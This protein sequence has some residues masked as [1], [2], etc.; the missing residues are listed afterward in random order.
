MNHP[1]RDVNQALIRLNDA[2]CSWE[3]ATGR[4]SILVLREDGGFVHRTASGKPTIP[5]DIEDGFLLA[6]IT[7]APL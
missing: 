1:D 3:R 4:N 5:D 7:S 6:Q 2:L